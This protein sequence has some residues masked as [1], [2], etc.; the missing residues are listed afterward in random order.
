MVG[1]LNGG[2]CKQ[3]ETK[4]Q[5]QLCCVTLGKSLSLSEFRSSPLK[6]R[7]IALFLPLISFL[8]VSKERTVIE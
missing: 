4:F 7:I 8:Q 5:A 6:Q 2:F 1:H 3:K